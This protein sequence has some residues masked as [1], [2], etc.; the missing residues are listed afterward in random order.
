MASQHI[1]TFKDGLLPPSKFE[2]VPG[3]SLAKDGYLRLAK[4]LP[5]AWAGQRARLERAESR[6]FLV[7]VSYYEALI[8]KDSFGDGINLLYFD[9]EFVLIFS[10]DERLGVRDFSRVWCNVGTGDSSF[11]CRSNVLAPE[12]RALW[13]DGTESTMRN[14]YGGIIGYLHPDLLK[15]FAQ[16]VMQ[17]W[18]AWPSKSANHRMRGDQRYTS[19]IPR[20]SWA[21]DLETFIYCTEYSKPGFRFYKK[22]P[23]SVL[24]ELPRINTLIPF[25]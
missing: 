10:W 11:G 19:R 13:T 7:P 5:E 1:W 12:L 21:E 3:L 25:E 6:A 18:D 24:S 15:Y 16:R 23:T 8:N 14:K 22:F 2:H 20:H 4:D 17:A 9:D